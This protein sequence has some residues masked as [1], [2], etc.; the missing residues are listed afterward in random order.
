MSIQMSSAI[1][2]D[3]DT[4]SEDAL[5]LIMALRSSGERVIAITLGVEKPLARSLTSA[6]SFHGKDGFGDH[7]PV[8]L[9]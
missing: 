7:G 2:I 9:A 3:T 1:L 8:R 4:A 6:D 5:A